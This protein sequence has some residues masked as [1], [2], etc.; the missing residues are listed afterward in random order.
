MCEWMT[1]R[2]HRGLFGTDLGDTWGSIQIFNRVVNGIVMEGSYEDW[3]TDREAEAARSPYM[4]FTTGGYPETRRYRTTIKAKELNI[5]GQSGAVYNSSVIYAAAL[6]KATLPYCVASRGETVEALRAAAPEMWAHVDG[7]VEADA[8]IPMIDSN[9]SIFKHLM[10][11]MLFANNNY[12]RFMH[13]NF[14]VAVEASGLLTPKYSFQPFRIDPPVGSTFSVSTL[15]RVTFWLSILNYILVL[16]RTWGEFKAAR[17]VTQKY[18]SVIHYFTSVYTLLELFNL[19]CNYSGLGLRIYNLLLPGRQKLLDHINRAVPVGVGVFDTDVQM[20]IRVQGSVLVLRALSVVSAVLLVFKYLE[21]V[22]KS[23]FGPSYYLTGTTLGRAG[24]TLQAL[25]FIFLL[26]LV[27]FALMG[28]WLFGADHHEFS[29]PVW[30]FLTLFKCVAGSGSIYKS[31][32]RTHPTVGAIYFTVFTL[33]HLIL[34]TPLFLAIITD[35]Y[36]VR[37]AQLQNVEDRRK[38][39]LEAMERKQKK[40]AHNKLG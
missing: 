21:L 14:H 15:M 20:L 31:L 24:S 7:A 23:R 10:I 18:G 39:R 17:K 2:F 28:M 16:A 4:P 37:S 35:A 29:D 33:V 25:F 30:A 13:A 5:A 11:T 27:A 1:D 38:E 26:V 19:G 6:I 36:Q 32:M 12:E 9:T 34:V 8:G 40:E 22:P 3:R